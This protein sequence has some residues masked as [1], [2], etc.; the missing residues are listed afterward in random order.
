MPIE[1]RAPASRGLGAC[2]LTFKGKE[3]SSFL[4]AIDTILF[5]QTGSVFDKQLVLLADYC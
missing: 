1:T 5:H 3:S 4:D 2:P